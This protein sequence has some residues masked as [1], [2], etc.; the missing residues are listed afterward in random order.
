[1]KTTVAI[2]TERV[3]EHIYAFC[4]LDFFTDKSPRPEVLGRDNRDALMCLILHSAAGLV[5]GL[6]TRVTATNLDEEPFERILTIELDLPDQ[7]T[8]TALRPLLEAA[9]AA[10]VMSTA[11]SGSKAQ[12][13]ATY[14][15]LYERNMASV[16]AVLAD[17]DKPGRLS[18][19]YY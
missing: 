10:S 12:L 17:G 1:M 8:Y 5:F 11:Y 16:L 3:L 18:L 4:A 19:S 7:S 9:L 13:S 2:D 14:G 15:A 6:G